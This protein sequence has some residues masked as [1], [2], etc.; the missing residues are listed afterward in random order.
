MSN[1][2]TDATVYVLI[3]GVSF[4]QRVV[5]LRSMLEFIGAV[6][7]WT[8]SSNPGA[9][10]P[11]F[12]GAPGE[13]PYLQTQVGHF[14]V[15]SVTPYGDYGAPWTLYMTTTVHRTFDDG[16][17]EDAGPF[18]EQREVLLQSP[19]GFFFAYGP[20]M[21]QTGTDPLRYTEV[22]GADRCSSWQGPA[23]HVPL[24]MTLTH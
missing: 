24:T 23:A 22:N 1:D 7:D 3:N 16:S 10:W 11:E 4:P 14:V 8:C 12:P 21:V 17:T 18:Q 5:V 20:G 19:G 2:E 6:G 15:D 13:V 9:P